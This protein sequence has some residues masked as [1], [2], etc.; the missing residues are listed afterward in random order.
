MTSSSVSIEKDSFSCFPVLKSLHFEQLGELPGIE[1]QNLD[2]KTICELLLLDSLNV[3][4]IV[5]RLILEATASFIK[6]TKLLD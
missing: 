5:N 6:A 2:S 3:N 1:I 4:V